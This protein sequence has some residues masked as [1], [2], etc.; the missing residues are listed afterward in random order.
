MKF[1]N[2]SDH[3]INKNTDDIVYRFANDEEIRYRKENDRIYMLTNFEEIFEVPSSEMSIEDFDRIKL[4]S[5]KD[6]HETEKKDKRDNRQNVSINNL[7]ETMCTADRST[8]Q[9][10]FDYLAALKALPEIRTID[11]AIAI[12]NECLTEIQKRRYLLYHFS[13]M[14]TLEIAKFEGITQ[15][16]VFESILSAQKKIEK[17]FFKKRKNTL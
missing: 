7:T 4:I 3:A 2:K 9:E 12:I 17:Y 16:S 10:Y 13:G 6:Y 11:N 15:P 1:D 5:K 14:N 8:E